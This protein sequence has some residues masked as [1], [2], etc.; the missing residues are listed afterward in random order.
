MDSV[1]NELLITLNDIKDVLTDEDASQS[2]RLSS[3]SSR[4][5]LEFCFF[6]N[7]LTILAVMFTVV[8]DSNKSYL[9]QICDSALL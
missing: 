6:S 4:A 2:P 9:R 5:R 7:K 1:L 3:H 8:Y